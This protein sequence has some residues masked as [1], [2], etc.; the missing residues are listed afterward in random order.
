MRA[1]NLLSRK[2][3][4]PINFPGLATIGR[5]GLLHARRL[6]GEIEPDIAHQD[7]ASLEGF[8]MEKLPALACKSADHRRRVEGALVKVNE[9]DAPLARMGIVESQCLRLDMELP[10]GTAY[11]EFFEVRVAVEKL[12]MVGNAVVLNPDVRIVQAI[13][14]PAD[15]RLPVANEEVEVVRAI[16]LRQVCWVVSGLG[17][18]RE[19]QHN[20]DREQRKFA[21]SHQ[22]SSSHLMDARQSI[23]LADVVEPETPAL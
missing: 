10:V 11:V 9:V 5:V 8:L 17:V 3:A 20:A 1:F 14:K 7:C 16:A 18:K 2:L 12:V 15:M 6:G 19:A 22:D 23:S 4:N 21:G 13:G